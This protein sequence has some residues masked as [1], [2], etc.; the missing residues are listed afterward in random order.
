MLVDVA[1]VEYLF[2]LENLLGE[3]GLE[4]EVPDVM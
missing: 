2:A 1:K 3:H 4:A